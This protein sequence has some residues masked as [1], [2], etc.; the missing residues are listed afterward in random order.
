MR[1]SHL[2]RRCV[3]PQA[4]GDADGGQDGEEREGRSSDRQR[5]N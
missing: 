5:A 3:T 2:V 4:G 1:A